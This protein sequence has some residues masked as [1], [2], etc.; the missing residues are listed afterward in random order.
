M[1]LQKIAKLELTPPHIKKTDCGYVDHSHFPS[2]RS[3][4]LQQEWISAPSSSAGS[5]TVVTAVASADGTAPAAGSVQLLNTFWNIYRTKDNKWYAFKVILSHW[6]FIILKCAISN[7]KNNS[8]SYWFSQNRMHE[9]RDFTPVP[10]HGASVHFLPVVEETIGCARDRNR[11]VQ[12][13]RFRYGQ[14]QL[15]LQL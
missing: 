8:F 4:G 5:R 13:Q 7:K 6:P 2:L 11:G 15:T 9:M 3:S 10:F 14:K 1:K 12:A